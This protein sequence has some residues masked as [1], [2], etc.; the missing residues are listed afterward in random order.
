MI[1]EE[2][3]VCSKPSRRDFLK[4]SGT[5]LTGAPATSAA[6]SASWPPGRSS[7]S[8]S[9]PSPHVPPPLPVSLMLPLLSPSLST[10]LPS[11]SLCHHHRRIRCRRCQCRSFQEVQ[12]LNAGF[13]L[14][15][16]QSHAGGGK[17]TA[18]WQADKAGGKEAGGN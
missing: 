16:S 10:A 6:N 8:A 3:P 15:P 17:G 14:K 18:R 2:K 1:R 12:S 5:T 9:T 13:R 4:V 11:P 7:V